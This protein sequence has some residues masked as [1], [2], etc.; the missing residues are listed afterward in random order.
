MVWRHPTEINWILL[1]LIWKYI[2]CAVVHVLRVCKNVNIIF[3]IKTSY[4]ICEKWRAF[5]CKPYIRSSNYCMKLNI[6]VFILEMV[7]I[8]SVCFSLT[9]WS[10]CIWRLTLFSV[11][12]FAFWSML[13]VLL[14]VFSDANG[15][16]AHLP[17]VTNFWVI[18]IIACFFLQKHFPSVITGVNVTALL[19]LP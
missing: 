8:N 11:K 12:A 5:S 6:F 1:V 16:A 18:W 13:Y 2:W 7:D 17:R 14:V 4:F 15:R 3:N 9:S 10:R 19:P